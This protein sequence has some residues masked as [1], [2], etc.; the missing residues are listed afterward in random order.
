MSG[1]QALV[2]SLKTEGVRTIFGLPGVQLD[3][4]FDAL[5]AERERI[6]TSSTV[7][8]ASPPTPPRI[9]TFPSGSS[10]DDR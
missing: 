5:Y 6:R 3:W 1:G 7:P 10:A 4:A 2:Q 8:T 9:S